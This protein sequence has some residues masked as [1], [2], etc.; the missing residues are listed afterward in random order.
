MNWQVLSC[1]KVEWQHLLH[2]GNTSARQDIPKRI[3]NT[4]RFFPSFCDIQSFCLSACYPLCLCREGG[5]TSV[6]LQEDGVEVVASGNHSEVHCTILYPILYQC[7]TPYH[8][9]TVRGGNH[10]GH[11]LCSPSAS[12]HIT[13]SFSTFRIQNMLWFFKISVL[14]EMFLSIAPC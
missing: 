1:K 13:A 11:F 5:K 10:T 8:A 14:A 12:L 7:T 3:F 2:F 6:E 9:G 4:G